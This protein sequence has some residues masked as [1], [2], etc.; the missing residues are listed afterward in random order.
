MIDYIKKI[1]KE[2]MMF[3]TSYSIGA[4]EGPH[5]VNQKPGGDFLLVKKKKN[6]I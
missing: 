2:I 6:T 1:F 3:T 4:F 5:G